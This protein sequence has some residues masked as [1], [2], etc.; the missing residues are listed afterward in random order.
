M[1]P[2]FAVFHLTDKP[3]LLGLRDTKN[4]ENLS[5]EAIGRKLGTISK[6]AILVL[7]CF[8]TLL[9]DKQ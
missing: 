6:N 1:P 8:Q 7:I 3:I 2:I 5:G 9:G 4:G